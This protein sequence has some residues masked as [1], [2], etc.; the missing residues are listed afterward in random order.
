LTRSA[1]EKHHWI[2]RIERP[3]LPLANLVEHRISDRLMRSG[4]TTVP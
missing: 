3:V 4:E 1:V 2:D